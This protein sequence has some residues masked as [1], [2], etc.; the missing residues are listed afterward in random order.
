MAR[1]VLDS[2]RPWRARWDYA[3]GLGQ[4]VA[5]EPIL[6]RSCV[7]PPSGCDLNCR[8]DELRVSVARRAPV[9][10]EVEG[11][12]GP[13]TLVCVGALAQWHNSPA[14]LTGPGRPL[15]LS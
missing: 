5:R 4:A 14:L 13:A 6:D 9:R 7:Y 1:T 11:C 15:R 8:G 2:M 12:A 10:R 3:R